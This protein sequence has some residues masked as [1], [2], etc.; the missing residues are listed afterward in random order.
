[1]LRFFDKEGRDITEE[2]TSTRQYCANP[3]CLG[4]PWCSAWGIY[5]AQEPE[6]TVP[7]S[8]STRMEVSGSGDMEQGIDHILLELSQQLESHSPT[9]RLQQP[10]P[11]AAHTPY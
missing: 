3:G 11:T 2:F 9:G 8:A 7:E 5:Q 6:Q 1:M 10:H 4:E